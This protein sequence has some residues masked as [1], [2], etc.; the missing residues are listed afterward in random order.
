MKY[1]DV[2]KKVILR[3]EPMSAGQVPQQAATEPSDQDTWA[4]Q[5]PKIVDNPAL[6]QQFDTQGLDKQEI[7]KYSQ[8]IN[9]WKDGIQ[10]AIEQL[11]EMIK[12]ATSEKLAAAP[13]SD[14]F[15]SILK[16]VP[17]LKSDLA[18]FKSQVEDLGETVKLAIS[19][20]SKERK[21]KINSLGA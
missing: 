20:A 8:K 17:G 15:S 6:S 5:N 19:D 4:N 9:M 11:T 3:E 10:T 7:E 13:G 14:Q 18:S 1:Q 21:E 16:A 2:F 12:F